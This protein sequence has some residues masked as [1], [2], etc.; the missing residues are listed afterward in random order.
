MTDAEKQVFYALCIF[1]GVFWAIIES[2]IAYWL[3]KIYV[4]IDKR[5][6]ND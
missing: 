4:A 6:K 5:E 2:V 3:Y 1:L